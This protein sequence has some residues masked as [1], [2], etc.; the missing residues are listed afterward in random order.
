LRVGLTRPSGERLAVASRVPGTGYPLAGGVG[1]GAGAEFAV[2]SGARIEPGG[3]LNLWRLPLGTRSEVD[4]AAGGARVHLVGHRIERGVVTGGEAAV[5]LLV[6]E[7]RGPA[8]GLRAELALLA[9]DTLLVREAQPVGG[10]RP[11]D[12]WITGEL[13]QDLRSLRV[14]AMAPAGTV[15]LWLRLLGADGAVSEPL[16][17]GKLEI[18]QRPREFRAPSPEHPLGIRFGDFAELIGYDLGPAPLRPGGTLAVKLYW[19]ARA[20][21]ER[22]YVVFVHLIDGLDRIR[23]QVDAEPAAGGAPTR[24]WAPG[25]VIVDERAIPIAP[26]APPG[27]YRLAVGFYFPDSGER[28][29]VVEPPL[30]DRALFGNLALLSS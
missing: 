10:A 12:G 5:V 28:V 7:G 20:P 23:G 18:V 26:D 27:P 19:R 9:G 1:R 2:V 4:L 16:R 6:W 8:P 24:T 29:P 22:N 13:L 17:L 21:S 30:G 15:D 14:P 3:R 25:E 11:I